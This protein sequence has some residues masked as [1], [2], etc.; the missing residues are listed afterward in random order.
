[1]TKEADQRYSVSFRGGTCGH[2]I[3]ML[4][5]YSL[6]NRTDDVVYE[7]TGGS[8]TPVHEWFSE[9]TEGLEGK[10]EVLSVYQSTKLRE[11]SPYNFLIQPMPFVIPNLDEL[12]NV[13][14]NF[15][16][17][18]ITCDR[19]DLL[20]A[21]VN[22]FYKRHAPSLWNS[23][24]VDVYNI[25]KNTDAIY[26]K[27][28]NNLSELTPSEIK[29]VLEFNSTREHL[30]KRNMLTRY[31]SEDCPFVEN[32]FSI[33]EKYKENVFLINFN[34]ILNNKSAVLSKINIITG[35][36]ITADLERQYDRYLDLQTQLDSKIPF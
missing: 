28:I 20:K 15:K 36:E 30:L 19:E 31:S 9:N 25:I 7:A 17:I 27:N 18:I 32:N 29:A 3:C 6:S 12:Y 14:P 23:E 13:N 22:Y 1:M 26:N 34:D 5:I 33:P 2:F 21:E 8:H 11:V 35:K 10:F 4:I 24:F 16:H